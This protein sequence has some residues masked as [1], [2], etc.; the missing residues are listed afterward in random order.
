VFSPISAED[1]SK[2]SPDSIMHQVILWQILTR[3]FEYSYYMQFL[4]KIIKCHLQLILVKTP[5]F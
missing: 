3:Y 1:D 2:L 5:H 4:I